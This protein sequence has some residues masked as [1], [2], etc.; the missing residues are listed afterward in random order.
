MPA[1]GWVETW[2]SIVL[3][4][5]VG[6]GVVVGL[7]TRL[8]VGTRREG[9]WRCGFLTALG[10]VGGT[11]L[12]MLVFVPQLWLAPAWGLA[13]MVLLATCDF[14]SSRQAEAW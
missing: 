10:L 3:A 4:L 1:E 6:L 7:A 9:L 11:T 12:A 5:T 2:P 13:I 14:G 8:S